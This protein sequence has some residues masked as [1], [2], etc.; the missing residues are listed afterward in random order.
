[1][2]SSREWQGYW[3]RKTE[4]E[5]KNMGLVSPN[6]QGDSY[7]ENGRHNS[8]LFAP[9]RSDL[10]EFVCNLY[11]FVCIFSPFCAGSVRKGAEKCP[12]FVRF[13]NKTI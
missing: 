6:F 4:I 1:M 5:T 11:E 7:D 3:Q 12:T 8:P 2:R 9:F 13:L 10:Y